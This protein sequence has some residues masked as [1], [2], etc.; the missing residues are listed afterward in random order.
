[1]AGKMLQ[2]SNV[3]KHIDGPYFHDIGMMPINTL[4]APYNRK[5]LLCTLTTR[6]RLFVPAIIMRQTVCASGE[7]HRE[8][9]KP[10]LTSLI[11]Q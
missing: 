10:S 1:M 5:Q 6:I 3:Y 11:L 7:L 9:V 8:R 2:H 4:T